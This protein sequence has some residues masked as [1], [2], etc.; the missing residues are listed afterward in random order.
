MNESKFKTLR[1]IESVRNFLNLVIK[2]LMNRQEKHDQTKLE[3]PEVE[4]FDKYTPLLRGLT[5]GSDEYK[6]IMK[7]MKVA[8]EH[9]N[10]WN[11]HHP[12]FH[13]G[14]YVCSK[15]HTKWTCGTEPIICDNCGYE[16]CQKRES[17]IDGMNLIDLIEMIC[18]WKAAGLRHD[19]GDIFKSIDINKERFGI[20]EQLVQILKN[21]AD[22]IN[23]Q[24]VFHKANES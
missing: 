7:E 17:G 13:E 4:I 6:K 22:F 16:K 8:I 14:I 15:C 11:R 20:S 3:S 10:K 18:D 2:E 21:T 23:H 9:H 1:H 19:G 24:N 5:Y 12:E